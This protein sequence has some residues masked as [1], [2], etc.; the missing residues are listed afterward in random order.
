MYRRVGLLLLCAVLS[1]AGCAE[2]GLRDG[3]GQDEKAVEAT[4]SAPGGLVPLGP[5]DGRPAVNR[6]IELG[7]GT[8]APRYTDTL[9]GTCINEQPCRGFGER[10]E[11]G[12]LYCACFGRQQGCGET[13]RCDLEKKA[14]VPA[15]EPPFKRAPTP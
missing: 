4:T 8:C 5:P 3:S 6:P 9:V 2:L 12:A 1:G 13:E 7:S 14:C 15:G 11:R 10:D